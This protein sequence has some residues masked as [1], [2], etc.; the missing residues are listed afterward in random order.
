M[1]VKAEVRMLAKQR[2]KIRTVFSDGRL[3]WRKAFNDHRG[4]RMLA[5]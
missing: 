1:L 5:K 4:N 3:Y 2:L